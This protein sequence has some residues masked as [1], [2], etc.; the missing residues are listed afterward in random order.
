MA[1]CE[2]AIL[3]DYAFQDVNR[4]MCIIGAFSEVTA[5]AVPAVHNAAALVLRI[6]GDANE[7]VTVKVEIVRPTNGLLG[8]VEGE[9]QLGGTGTGELHL[10]LNQ[11]P[12]PDWGPYS[13]NVYF[14]DTLMKTVGFVVQRP[15]G[16]GAK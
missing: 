16:A 14:G 2:W 10:A 7:R 11:L 12:L 5:T 4:K 9:L 1:D 15:K 6:T 3:C 13:F 8:Q